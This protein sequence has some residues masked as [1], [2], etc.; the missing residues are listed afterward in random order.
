MSKVGTIKIL[1]LA[2]NPADTSPLRLDKEI[3]AI[4]TAL[5]KT[6]Y[7]D[8]FDIKQHWAVSIAELQG[9]LQRHQPHIVHFSGHGSSSGDIILETSNRSDDS[10]RNRELLEGNKT[11]GSG[12]PGHV[13]PRA[14]SD[15]FRLLKDNIRCVVLNACYSEDQAQGIA[16]HI[17][18]VI[19]MNT[20]IGDKAAIEFAASFYQG[21][22]YGRTIQDAFELGRNQIDLAGLNEQDTPQIKALNIDPSKLTFVVLGGAEPT[23]K[24]HE[25]RTHRRID[26]SGDRVAGKRVYSPAKRIAGTKTT[27]RLDHFTDRVEQRADLKALVEKN[28]HR[29]IQICGSSGIGKTTL[30]TKVFDELE[31]DPSIEG[32][33]LRRHQHHQHPRD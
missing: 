9:L 10:D 23:T 16:E 30:I 33:C 1:F 4:D 24:A 18:C 6:K 29:L 14:L 20:T 17:D 21:L 32:F 11:S 3:Q 7:R 5:Q 15:L 13:S 25:D 27:A 26:E 8:N 28:Q 19:G 31:D 22:G 2:A 12:Q